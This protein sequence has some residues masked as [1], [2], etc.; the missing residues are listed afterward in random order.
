M[1][2]VEQHFG[3]CVEETISCKPYGAELVQKLGEYYYVIM[4]LTTLLIRSVTYISY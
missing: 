2:A 3:V 1:L 4:T